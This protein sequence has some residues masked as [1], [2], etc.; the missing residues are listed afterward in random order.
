MKVH[1]TFT[2]TDGSMGFK[3]GRKYEFEIESN[4]LMCEEV[5]TA[6]PYDSVAA[7]LRNWSEID[8]LEIRT[9]IRR[10]PRLFDS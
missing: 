8:V 3:K 1:A 2:G 10:E 9:G 5:K 4:V 7:F 6:C